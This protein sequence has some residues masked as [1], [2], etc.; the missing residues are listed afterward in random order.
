MIVA[1]KLRALTDRVAA[2]D[3][4]DAGFLPGLFDEAW[5]T[6]RAKALFVLF[7]GTLDYPLTRY[8]LDRFDRLT[9]S[10]FQNKLVRVLNQSAVLDRRAM[11]D[12]AKAVLAPML[13]LEA[14][15]VE[16]VERIQRGE[17]R[18]ELVLPF[19]EALAAALRHHPALKW[20]A[21]NAKAH[22]AKKSGA[23]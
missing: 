11:I 15:Q 7:S 5:P 14:N 18:P 22:H 12:R 23:S 3:V 6:P 2:R 17:Y 13:D 16:Y 21:Q 10:E 1:G 8:S 9:E 4:Y 20:K 19:G